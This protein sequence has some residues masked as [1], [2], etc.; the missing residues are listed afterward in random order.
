MRVCVCMCLCVHLVGDAGLN[1]RWESLY[2]FLHAHM[3]WCVRLLSARE[4]LRAC[5]R[6]CFSFFFAA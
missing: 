4:I 3:S 6:G 2:A 5:S 1:V